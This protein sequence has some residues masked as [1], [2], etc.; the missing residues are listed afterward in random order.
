MERV[1]VVYLF[2]DGESVPSGAW[3]L[4]G[5]IHKQDMD[6]FTAC[7]VKKKSKIK[8]LKKVFVVFIFYFTS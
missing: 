2:I 5:F 4:Y 7:Q 8:T 3:L 1:D 6:S